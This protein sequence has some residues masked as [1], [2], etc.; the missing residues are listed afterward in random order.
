MRVNAVTAKE[1][2]TGYNLGA[3]SRTQEELSA[4]VIT[5]AETMIAS[6]AATNPATC[7]A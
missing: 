4:S 5:S 2:H 7:A 1:Q 3:G 6:C